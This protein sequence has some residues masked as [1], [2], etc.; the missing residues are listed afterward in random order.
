MPPTTVKCSQA[1]LGSTYT[2]QEQRD[3]VY[4]QVLSGQHTADSTTLDKLL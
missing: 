1:L 3:P 2:L 4:P